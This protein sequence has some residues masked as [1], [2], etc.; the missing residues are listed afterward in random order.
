MY[1]SADK[2]NALDHHP[3]NKVTHEKHS[4]GTSLLE[5]SAELY[6]LKD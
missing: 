1:G 6:V 5:A 2:N 3:E 4:T